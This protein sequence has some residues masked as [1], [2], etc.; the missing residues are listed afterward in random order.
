VWTFTTDKY[1]IFQLSKTREATIAHEFLK[2]YNGILIT[3]FYSGYDVIACR[4]QKCWVH[5]IRDLNDDLWMSPF[6]S[7]YETFVSEVRNLIIPI[8]EVVQQYG[9]KKR[10]LYKF[11]QQVSAFYTKT[12]TGKQYTSELVI[13]YQQRFVRYRDSLFTFLEYDGI[14]WHNNTAERALRHIAKQQQIS[15]SFHEA[16]THQ[17]LRLLGIKQT[18]RFQNKSFFRFLLSREIDIDQ[19][20]KGKPLKRSMLLN[21]FNS[22][23]QEDSAT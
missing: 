21:S 17:Y 16:A 20:E 8:M 3:D 15:M 12:I 11:I 4:Q 19:F 9:L 1:V 7:E 18:C 14:P 5:L 23:G 2:N 10:H 6:D 13:K 22:P